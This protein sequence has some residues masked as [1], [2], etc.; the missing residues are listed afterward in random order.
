MAKAKQSGLAKA[1]KEKLSDATEV[2]RA[3][4]FTGRQSNEVAA[5]TFLALL[6]LKPSQPWEC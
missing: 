6:D 4:G 3:L 2:L 1:R 5:Y